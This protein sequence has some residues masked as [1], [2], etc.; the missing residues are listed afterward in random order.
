MTSKNNRRDHIIRVQPKSEP[1]SRPDNPPSEPPSILPVSLTPLPVQMSED[2]LSWIDGMKLDDTP[3]SRTSEPIQTPTPSVSSPEHKTPSTPPPIYHHTHV[4]RERL[5]P[6]PESEI[7]KVVSPAL[8][9]RKSSV[10]DGHIPPFLPETHEQS[11]AS[12][13]LARDSIIVSTA[14]P[15]PPKNVRNLPPEM[16]WLVEYAATR[17]AIKLDRDER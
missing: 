14:P 4:V 11:H 8:L 16:E 2:R 6:P 15:S 3:I 9:S 7:D 13:L 10:W 12:L 1:N 5:T 17:N